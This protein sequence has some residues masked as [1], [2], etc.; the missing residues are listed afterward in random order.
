M[1]N[2]SVDY[3]VLDYNIDLAFIPDCVWPQCPRARAH[4]ISIGLS[5]LLRCD[6]PIR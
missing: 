6:S 3:D 4:E 1:K 5:P 2:D